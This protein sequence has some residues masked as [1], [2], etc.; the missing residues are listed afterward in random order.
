MKI[1]FYVLILASFIHSQDSYVNFE[2]L[3]YGKK[4]IVDS[5]ILINTNSA[6]DTVLYFSTQ[7]FNDN[8]ADDETILNQEITPLIFL[9]YRKSGINSYQLLYNNK[10]SKIYALQSNKIFQYKFISK[11]GV[12]KGETGL[13]VTAPL[14]CSF[15]DIVLFISP[16]LNFYFE[17]G[18]PSF[19]ATISADETRKSYRK[20]WVSIIKNDLLIQLQEID[21]KYFSEED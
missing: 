13:K 16:K 9:V 7:M 17:Y 14:D 6:K 21:L 10:I 18:H 4:E 19:E 3:G 20:E 12:I 5:L 8:F 11:T 1:I 2:H 15:S